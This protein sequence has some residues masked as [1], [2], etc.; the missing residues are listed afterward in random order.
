[1]PPLRVW[2]RIRRRTNSP[3]EERDCCF[4]MRNIGRRGRRRKRRP[5]SAEQI[6]ILEAKFQEKR[7]LGCKE[8]EELGAQ[9]G[10]DESQQTTLAQKSASIKNRYFI[11]CTPYFIYYCSAFSIQTMSTHESASTTWH[12][13]T[14]SCD[15]LP[16]HRHYNAASNSHI[17]TNSSPGVNKSQGGIS[18]GYDR[19]HFGYPSPAMN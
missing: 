19:C 17:S 15:Q 6:E 8:R 16:S 11:T 10:L 18:L 7:H 4:I 12:S 14:M 5:F 3:T 1:M 2:N 13:S 9:T